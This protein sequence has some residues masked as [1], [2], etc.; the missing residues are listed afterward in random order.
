MRIDIL[1]LF[2]NMFAGPFSESI[3]KRA[4]ERGL[5]SVAVHDLRDYTHDPHHTADDSPYGGGAGMILKPEPI[6]AAVADLKAKA[7]QEGS[8]PLAVLL[9]PQG[10]SFSH[11]IAQ[12]LSARPHLLLICGHYEG[13]DERVI[14]HLVDD[15]ISI[16]DYLL[17]GGEL[18]AMV[19]VDAVARLIPGVLGSDKANE[20]DSHA[21]GLLEYPQYTRPRVYQ[22]H[23]VPPILLSGDHAAI[24][25][26]RREQA[27]QRTQRRRP[28][29]L[30]K[31]TSQRA[32]A[33]TKT[34]IET[35]KPPNPTP[36]NQGSFTMPQGDKKSPD[37]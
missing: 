31:A 35:E 33:E 28:D 20:E 1:S 9:T 30:Q 14:E 6:F 17:T 32:E 22:G 11:Q 10:R 25:R 12:E 27:I 21:W 37:F 5:I 8:I 15:E 26:W 16:G 2:P 18:A 34:E 23:E 7:A 13:V 3:I 36:E 19:I 29:L 24:A 4:V